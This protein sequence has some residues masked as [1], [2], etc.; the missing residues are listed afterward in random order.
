G[1]IDVAGTL[2]D[3]ELRT[4]GTFLPLPTPGYAIPPT[5]I[6]V[7]Y[8]DGS[9]RIERVDVSKVMNASVTATVP[10][11][12]SFRDGARILSDRPMEGSIVIEPLADGALSDFAPYVKGV[13]RLEGILT[14]RVEA[15]G[16]PSSPRLTGAMTLTNGE[17]RVTGVQ[18]SA[19]DISGRVDF[20]DDV[21]RLTSLTAKSGEEGSLLATGWAKVSNYQPVDYQVD[22]SARDFPLQSIPDV[23]LVL[24]G[25]LRARLTDWHG[26]KI[27]MLTGNVAVKEAIIM[28][29]LGSASGSG[30]TELALPT[31]R[32]DWLANIDVNAPKN[33]WIRNPDLN[34]ELA[35]EDL[36]FLRDE[37]GMYF[38]GELI[39]LRGSYKLY[40]NKFTI[41]S[42]TM[43]FSASETLRPSMHIEAY[44]PY[45]GGNTDAGN[46]Y[47]VLSWPYDKVEP[48]ISLSYDEPGYSESDIWA[49]L[50]GNIVS[51]GVATNALERAINAQM[52]G[53]F[54]VDVEQR[55]REDATGAGPPE[56]ETLIGVGRYFWEDIYLQYRRGLSIEGAQELDVEYRLSNRFLLRSQFIYNSRRNRAGIAGQ[57]TDEFNLDLKYRFEY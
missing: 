5:S 54:T 29:D 41:T 42:G 4:Q 45:R 13:S 18:E 3:P 21:V 35:S 39:V 46:I 24:G 32:P 51:G 12:I 16:T 19:T 36:V 2:D 26:E 53:G 49:M 57:N 56:Q 31:D 6:D 50:G 9:L 52:A 22:V 20:V 10:M 27:P 23:E 47:L 44:T 33:V 14:G 11:T 30:G 28:K 8:R 1:V 37:R 34:V 7:A 38:R 15:S 40:G 17:L 48:Q 43:D 25:K 55:K